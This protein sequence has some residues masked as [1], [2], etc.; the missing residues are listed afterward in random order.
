MIS[1]V[2]PSLVSLAAGMASR[3]GSQKQTKGFCP[4]KENI[5]EYSIYDA[6]ETSFYKVILS[7][8]KI[9]QRSLKIILTLN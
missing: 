9:L 6:I 8:V 1:S 3:Y 2:N 5:M 4:N 7:F